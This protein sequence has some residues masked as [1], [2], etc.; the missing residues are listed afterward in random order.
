MAI[1]ATEDPIE[2][3]QLWYTEAQA[4]ETRDKTTVALATVGT[5]GM[6]S[7]RMVLLKGVD[8]GGFVFY[9]NF[10]SR[11][12]RELLGTP[13]AGLCFHW[14]ST[15]RQVRVEG[16]VSV[17][18][19]DEAD[20]YFASRARGS[21]IGAWASLQSSP[22]SGNTELLKRVGQYT[23]KFGLGKVPRPPHWSGFKLTPR[24]IEFWKDGKFRLH[25]RLMYRR[26]EDGWNT[27]TLYP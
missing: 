10:E 23:A 19:A 22:L 25:D 5:D 26:T 27:E 17:V 11:K 13:K 20:A 18:P 16:D 9:T 24:A 4:S 1:T 3:F 2:L 15:K 7:V 8:E 14:K 6:P 21:Q 12:G